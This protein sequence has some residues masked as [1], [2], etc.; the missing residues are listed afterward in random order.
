MQILYR[1]NQRTSF[2]LR[3]LLR[4]LNIFYC[5]TPIFFLYNSLLLTWTIVSTDIGQMTVTKPFKIYPNFKIIWML[6]IHF[7]TFTRIFQLF[8]CLYGKIAQRFFISCTVIFW[9]LLY[10]IFFEVSKTFIFIYK[11][12]MT[13]D[14]RN[15]FLTIPFILKQLYTNIAN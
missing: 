14:H 2:Q 1:G 15:L 3:Y 6:S 9:Y 8:Y 11:E 13:V 12:C 4:N 10:H 7:Y 5:S